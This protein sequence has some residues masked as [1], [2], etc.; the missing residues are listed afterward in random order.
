MYVSPECGLR[1]WLG[2]RSEENL[3][4]NAA[5]TIKPGDVVWDVGANMGV[6]SFAAAGLA[7]PSGRVFSFEPDAVLVSL[8]RRSARLNP[9]AARVEVIPCAVS[10]AVSLAQFNI[11]RRSRAAN[12]LAGFGST[13]TGGV[14]ET[15]TV[16]TV[17]LDWMAERIPL[18]DVLKIDV[19]D[20]ELNVFRGA[21]RMLESKRPTLLFET[22]GPG[23]ARIS[24]LLREWGY[25]LYNG[26]LP[27]S[28]R[29]PLATAA[30]NTLAV[31]E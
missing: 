16:V 26:D 30:Y 13:Q 6:F 25:T 5:E 20:A 29:R 9:Q 14:R 19:E 3:L 8:L 31:V 28:E 17:T 23:P 24:P 22:R 1:Y 11:A 10:D 27:P 21:F 2:L 4:K 7:R 18:P 12:F 15:H